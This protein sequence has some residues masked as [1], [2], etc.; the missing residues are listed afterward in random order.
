MKRAFIVHG[1]ASYPENCWFPWLKNELEAKGFEVHAPK[2]PDTDNPRIQNWVPKLAETV[3]VPDEQSFFIGHSMG[4]QTI[5]RYLESL[6][7][8]LKVGGAV[9]VGGFFKRLTGLEDD[10]NAP[11][12][13]KHW[14]TESIDLEKVR[15]HLGKSIAIF[16]DNDPFVPLDNADDFR[17]KLG[18][19]I[20]IEHEKGHYCDDDGTKKLPIVLEFVLKISNSLL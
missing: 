1:W 6:S 10:P 11:E 12:T 4:C 3:G 18:S 20:I 7:N 8:D 2:L 9:F 17:E 19:E 16:S 14:M 5:A 13:E 15:S